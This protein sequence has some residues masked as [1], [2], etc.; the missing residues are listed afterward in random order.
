MPESWRWVFPSRP[1]NPSEPMGREDRRNVASRQ[2]RTGQRHPHTGSS[3]TRISTVETTVPLCRACEPPFT[4]S[5]SIG[6]K[7]SLGACQFDV[8]AHGFVSGL[9]VS[10]VFGVMVGVDRGKDGMM[11]VSVLRA[12]G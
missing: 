10:P 11:H 4:Q 1:P 7:V 5:N 6:E 8:R 3:I 12:A 2:S 9:H